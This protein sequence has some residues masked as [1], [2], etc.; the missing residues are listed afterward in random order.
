MNITADSPVLI[1]VWTDLGC[2]WCYVGK[3]R[4][5]TAIAEHPAGDR[6]MVR[7]RSFELNPNAP[8]EPETIE[9]AFIRSHGGDVRQV[10]DAE[11]R[12]QALAHR[13]GLPF[14]LERRNANT[15]DFHRLVHYAHTHGKGTEFFARVQDAFFAGDT[16]PYDPDQLA[17]HAEAVGLSATTVKEILASDAYADDV[18]ADVA[19]GRSLGV[20]GVPFMVFDRRFAAAGAQS[21]QAYSQALTQTL[22]AVDESAA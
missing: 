16:D 11:K 2:P 20:T 12:I 6:F 7:V 21:V 1:E 14:S 3:H 15:F 17:A 19:E 18:R 4:L 10:I 22:A 13:E 8:Y 9:S 5:D